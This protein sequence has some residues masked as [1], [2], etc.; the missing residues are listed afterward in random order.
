MKM[1]SD[2]TLKKMQEML[3]GV[4]S[5]GTGKICDNPLYK[6]AGKTGTAQVADGRKGYKGKKQYQASFCGYFPGR[7]SKILANS[8][9]K[10][11]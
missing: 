1:C 6:I 2:V 4:V 8:S 7:S 3:E 9:Y 11:P 5:E 10:R